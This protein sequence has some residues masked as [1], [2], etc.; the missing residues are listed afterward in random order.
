MV[1]EYYKFLQMAVHAALKASVDVLAIYD[2]D[3]SVE[4]KADFS[5]VTLADQKASRCIEM[6]LEP[7]GIKVVSEEGAFH[8]FASRS[9][10]NC[11]WLVDPVDGTKEFVKR[12]GEFTVNIALIEEGIPVLGIIY[13]P[14]LDELYFAMRGK[15]SWKMKGSGF[16]PALDLQAENWDRFAARLPLQDLPAVYT[17]VVSRSHPGLSLR[18]YISQLEVKHAMVNTIQ[19]GSSLKLCLL[20]EG[21]AHEYPRFG[22]TMEWD[23]AAGHCIL[24]ESGGNVLDLSKKESLVYNKTDL[25]NPEFVAVASVSRND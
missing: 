25:L 5:P 13:A 17:V 10:T 9:G 19:K 18:A 8:D 7:S 20:A 22:R 2:T 11:I 16:T 1:M 14:V 24:T 4:L 12:N 21:C 23:T 3:F 15:G 6:C